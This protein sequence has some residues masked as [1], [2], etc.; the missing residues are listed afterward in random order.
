MRTSPARSTPCSHHGGACRFGMMFAR[1]PIPAL[2]GTRHH[3]AGQHIFVV[4]MAGN[5]LSKPRDR[6]QAEFGW[7]WP[8]APPVAGSSQRSSSF[9]RNPSV[10]RPTTGSAEYR[11]QISAGAYLIRKRVADAAPGLSREGIS[12]RLAAPP[13]D[14][15]SQQYHS[16]CRAPKNW[17]DGAR[18][19]RFGRCPQCRQHRR[20]RRLRLLRPQIAAGNAPCRLAGSHDARQAAD[21]NE[22]L[23]GC[24]KRRT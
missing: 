10:A 20:I 17:F 23:T 4:A 12:R 14:R 22:V 24:G 9:P 21:P 3:A 13:G 8:F 7:C 16:N 19:D 11:P 2:T 18:A 15:D 5:L 1:L 6:R